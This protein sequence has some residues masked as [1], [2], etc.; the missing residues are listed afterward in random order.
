MQSDNAALRMAERARKRSRPVA[1]PEPDSLATI[2]RFQIMTGS[3]QPF[4]RHDSGPDDA[5][6]FIIFTCDT[7]LDIL[8]QI[9]YWAMDGTFKITPSQFY[10]TFV[11]HAV[12]GQRCTIPL[13]YILMPDKSETSYRRVFTALQNLAPNP[14]HPANCIADL[15]QASRSA[16]AEV[17]GGTL[18]T[19]FFHLCQCVMRKIREIGLAIA[20]NE[21]GNGI[22]RLMLKSIC[23]LAFVPLENVRGDFLI[24][25]QKLD[26]ERALYLAGTYRLIRDVYKYFWDNYVCNSARFPPREWNQRDRVTNRLPRFD[27]P[28]EGWHNGIQRTFGLHPALWTFTDRLVLEQS[29]CEIKWQ[30]FVNDQE[31]QRR[32]SVKWRRLTTNLERYVPTYPAGGVL[33]YLRRISHLFTLAKR[34]HIN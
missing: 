13:V 18:S 26:D 23:A 14:L 34:D 16:F 2:P 17:F 4:V 6:R 29:S 31:I 5:R 19:C 22:T 7:N 30:R 9:T 1:P 33:L 11:I 3:N 27:A 24:L 12:I 25:L 8:G 15:E 10:Q 32:A 20:Y 21:D 28:L